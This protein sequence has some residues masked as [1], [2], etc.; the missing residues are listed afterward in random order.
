VQAWIVEQLTHLTRIDTE[1]LLAQRYEKFRR[2][3]APR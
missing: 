3:G 2:I 1:A